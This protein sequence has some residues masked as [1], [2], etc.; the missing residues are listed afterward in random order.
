MSLVTL[1]VCVL[2]MGATRIDAGNCTTVAG[3]NPTD[4][5]WYSCL[6][7]ALGGCLNQSTFDAIEKHLTS[8]ACRKGTVDDTGVVT[9]QNAVRYCTTAKWKHFM[10]AV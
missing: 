10:V 6:M 4:I 5:D 9:C 8:C 1:L 2:L 7:P 3:L